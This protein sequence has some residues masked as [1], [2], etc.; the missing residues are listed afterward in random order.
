[1]RIELLGFSGCPNTPSLRENLAAAIQ[2]IDGGLAF[3]DIDQHELS[4]SDPRRGWPAPTILVDGHD[5]LGM[6]LPTGVAAGCRIY[7]GGAPTAD[8]IVV[9]LGRLAVITAA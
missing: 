6:P 9:R 3:A 7:N 5:L 1:M 4:E 8:E 2:Q